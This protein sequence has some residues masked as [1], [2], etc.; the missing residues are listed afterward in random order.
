[1]TFDSI[2]G[3]PF[4]EMAKAMRGC[5]SFPGLVRHPYDKCGAS[6][7]SDLTCTNLPRFR[8]PEPL[9]PAFQSC[10]ASF[11]LQGACFWGRGQAKV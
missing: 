6:D 8:D 4:L 1:M 3:D 2:Q 10:S 11:F 7:A 5:I 9:T